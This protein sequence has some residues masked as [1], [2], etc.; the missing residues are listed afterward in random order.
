MSPIWGKVQAAVRAFPAGTVKAGAR[1][2]RMAAQLSAQMSA[3]RGRR[4]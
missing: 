2:K 3:I 4:A 1:L